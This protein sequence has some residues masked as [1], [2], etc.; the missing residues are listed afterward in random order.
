M[1][2]KVKIN[3]SIMNYT[4]FYA[5]NSCFL[6]QRHGAPSAS[7]LAAEVGDTSYDPPTDMET[8]YSQLL[9]DSVTWDEGDQPIGSRVSDYSQLLDDSV[10]WDEGDQPIGSGEQGHVVSDNRETQYQTG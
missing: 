9:D 1:S 6:F 5:D 3:F 8:D 7:P 4:N 2:G 10:T